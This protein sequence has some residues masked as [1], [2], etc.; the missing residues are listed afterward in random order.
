MGDDGAHADEQA[1][2]G[3]DG[4]DEGL[5]RLDGLLGQGRLVD[6]LDFIRHHDFGDLR[7]LEALGEHDV[8]LV[9]H[10]DVALDA[11]VALFFFRQGSDEL[12]VLG[13]HLIERTLLALGN[14]DGG[15]V[16][17][18]VGEQALLD[19]ARGRRLLGDDLADLFI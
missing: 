13:V 1:E 9:R 11:H 14:G 3:H 18:L 7:F 15:L 5:A 17:E 19:G 6:D 4:H 10:V 12:F 2:H 16:L 8:N